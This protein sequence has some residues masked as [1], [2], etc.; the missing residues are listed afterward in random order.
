MSNQEISRAVALLRDGE[1]VAFPTE[2][3]YGLGADA[4]NETAVRAVFR[5]KGRPNDNPLIAHLAD[6][7]AARR[8][9]VFDSRAEGLAARFWPGPLTLVLRRRVES[10][11][12]ASVSGGLKTV[13][14]RVPSHDT[15]LELLRAFGR[16]VAAPSAN[17]SGRLSPTTADHVAQGLGDAVAMILDDGPCSLG[18]ESTVVGLDGPARLLRPGGVPREAIED[19]IGPLLAPLDEVLRAPGMM[20]SHYAP[21]LP[22]RLGATEPHLGE[23]FLG[24]GPA[25]DNATL[26]L[27]PSGDIDEA[28]AN[29]YAMLHALDRVEYYTA[30]AVT[31]IPHEG[32]GVAINDR[33]ERGAAR[34]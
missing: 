13:A 29:L 6:V 1:L 11:V 31:P 14:L 32:R 17:P 34:P 5:A 20:T 27:S 9:A 23:A 12:S 24:F 8:E 15:A 10:S 30:I 4:T 7:A 16:P 18:L 3:V 26:N 25:C 28:A 21:R 33:L 19:A 22:L 2:T